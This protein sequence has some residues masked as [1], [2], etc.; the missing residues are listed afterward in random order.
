MKR[1]AAIH[2]WLGLALALV[3]LAWTATGLLFHLK[4][5]WSGAYEMLDPARP[6]ATLD[7]ATL[8][9]ITAVV[10][11]A[12]QGDHPPP[13]T[14][15]SLSTTTLGPVYRVGRA[16]AAPL[17]VDARTGARLSPLDAAAAT[18]IA[19]DAASR[20]THPDR[21][22]TVSGT[23]VTDDAITVDFAG[24][25]HVR[26]SRHDGSLSQ[27]GPDTDRIDRYY[28]WHYLQLTG[29]HTVDRILAALAIAAT[30][31]LVLLGLALFVARFRR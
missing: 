19:S 17:L 10:A 31:A 21:F 4:P 2:R 30:W 26:V 29:N 13:V 6:D 23:T 14:D 28:R 25:A 7:P 15:L 1:V 12:G 8:Q 22:G 16:G 9:P 18:A 27:R 20:A 3:L 11:G 5:G 24:G